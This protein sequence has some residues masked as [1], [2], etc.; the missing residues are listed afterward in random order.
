MWMRL[1]CLW[2]KQNMLVNV[3]VKLV[4]GSPQMVEESE[5]RLSEEQI[6]ELI[7]TVTAALPGDPE[8]ESAASADAAD[9]DQGP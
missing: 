9:A 5:E 7:Q 6:E 4:C 8:Q 2:K 1:F 3:R